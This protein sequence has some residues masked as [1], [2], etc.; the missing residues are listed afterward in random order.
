MKE[1]KYTYV[2]VENDGLELPIFIADTLMEISNLTGFNLGCLYYAVLRNSLIAG[3]YRIRK[4]DFRD[5]DE[6]FNNI[7]DYL[8]F[9]KKEN[10]K[11]N[12]FKSLQRYR[13]YCFG[14]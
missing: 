7:T 5:P 13:Q 1:I 9:C 6:K 4:V 8:T 2:F 11:S 14:G 10:I 3:K 12:D